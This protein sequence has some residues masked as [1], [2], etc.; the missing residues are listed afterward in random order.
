MMCHRAWIPNKQLLKSVSQSYFIALHI[1]K[2]GK[3]STFLVKS[4]NTTAGLED[5]TQLGA[6]KV[7]DK[8]K[9]MFKSLSLEDRPKND[10]SI[11]M[12]EAHLEKT[13]SKKS[14]QSVNVTH[15]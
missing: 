15:S 11:T 7:V 14:I 13:A 2:L 6:L 3:E 10:V 9:A 4:R 5:F 12:A 8:N 1:A